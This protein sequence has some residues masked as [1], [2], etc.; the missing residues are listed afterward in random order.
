VPS[1]APRIVK[2]LSNTEKLTLGLNPHGS[3][4][5]MLVD[6]YAC[7]VDSIV[8]GADGPAWDRAGFDKL[9]AAVRADA[10][11]RTRETVRRVEQVLRVAAEVDRRLSGRAELA[12]LAAL[13]D[14]KAQWARLVHKGFVA[15][16]GFEQLAQ[17]PRYLTAMLHRIDRLTAD[18]RRD[19]V[20]MATV[21][22]V[23]AAYQNRIDALPPDRRPPTAL[24]EIGW[25]IEELRVSIFAQHLGTARPVSVQRIERALAE[26]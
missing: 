2:E 26:L 1:P 24:R 3:I 20:A 17:V 14:L 18:P 23:Q 25:M 21:S 13:T 12:L 10:E 5:A 4:A 7:A 16:T 19:A 6:C 9:M 11:S 15:E 22:T 8:A